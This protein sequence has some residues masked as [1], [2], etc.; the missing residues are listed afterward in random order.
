MKEISNK[1]LWIV[2]SALI[3]CSC[4][5]HKKITY[6]Q[7]VE[8][9]YVQQVTDDYEMRIQPD[10]LL[11]IFVNSKTKEL[12]E[13]FNLPLVSY[14]MGRTTSSN[15]R[16]LGYLVNKEGEINFPQLG[17]IKV[18]GLTRNELTD[19]IQQRLISDGYLNDPVVT[20]QFL[21][22]KVSVMGEVAR[23]GSIN[24]ESDRITIFDALS[25]AGDL[26]IYGQRD[27]VK[28]IREKDGNRTVTLVD[29]RSIEILNSP[30]YY[31]QQNDI[32]YVQPNKAKAGQRE[33]N[34]NRTVATWASITSVLLSA[35][36]IALTLAL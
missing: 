27:N 20:V 10:D 17:K 15:Q 2:L 22:F 4:A 25:S 29:L 14:Q 13:M 11:G 26:T 3:L 19:T 30:F 28:I 36:S 16:A 32:V 21:N 35:I 31:L 24:V 33:I 6:L 23:P 9:N 7:G 1:T 18:Q 12:V 8:E 5:S 34:Q